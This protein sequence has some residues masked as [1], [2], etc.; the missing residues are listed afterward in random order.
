MKTCFKIH[1]DDFDKRANEEF[2]EKMAEEGWLLKKRWYNLSKFEKTEP[3]KLKFDIYYSEYNYVSEEERQEFHSN[4]RTII[5]V[6]SN[7]HVSYT[8]ANENYSCVMKPDDAAKAVLTLKN[9]KSILPSPVIIILMICIL[10]D[11]RIKFTYN[12]FESLPFLEQRIY[13]IITMPELYIAMLFVV[14]YVIFLAIYE[15]VR[16]KKAVASFYNGENPDDRGRKKFI[17]ILSLFMMGVSVAF[18]ALFSLGNIASRGNDIPEVSDGIYLDVHDFGIADK[19]TDKGL[20]AGG[21]FIPCEMKQRKTLSADMILTQEFYLVNDTRIMLYQDIITY[22]NQKTALSAAELLL[23][24]GNKTYEEY[25]AEGFEKVYVSA[26][27]LIAVI[28][29]TLYRISIIEG[30]EIL[31]STDELLEIIKSKKLPG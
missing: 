10:N 24:D 23:K 1:P 25:E 14:A 31:P 4:G 29:S 22:R 28:D 19:I 3:Q 12:A 8:P 27:N 11:F 16:W 15:H 18:I 13:K 6:K 20:E 5:D 30:D 17:Y 26:E 9:R 7:V 21:K 2:Y